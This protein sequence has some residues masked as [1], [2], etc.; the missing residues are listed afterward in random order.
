L[1][2]ARRA[3]TASSGVSAG[4]SAV[5][6]ASQEPA[7]ALPDGSVDSEVQEAL[8][9]VLSQDP[10]ATATAKPAGTSDSA[11]GGDLTAGQPPA[12]V[13]AGN[14]PDTS[15]LLVIQPMLQKLNRLA[16]TVSSLRCEV[17]AL[18]VEVEMLKASNRDKDA[19]IRSL[20]SQA[21]L[22]KELSSVNEYVAM[23]Q[24]LDRLKFL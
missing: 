19:E 24:V 21:A 3:G 18:K 9:R 8:R 22:Q 7:V 16:E 2:S 17:D 11:G 20:R 15:T 12:G 23:E 6:G 4:V 14:D 10:G 5:P 1:K 13:P